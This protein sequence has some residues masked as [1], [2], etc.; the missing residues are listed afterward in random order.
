MPVRPGLGDILAGSDGGMLAAEKRGDERSTMTRSRFRTSV[1]LA[2]WLAASVFAPPLPAVELKPNTASAFDHYVSLTETQMEDDSRNGR[3]L[4]TDRLAAQRGDAIK[5]QLRRGETFVEPLRTLDDGHS[6]GVPHGLI[7]DWI[8]MAYIPGATLEET[9]SVLSDYDHHSEIYKPAVRDSKL[10]ERDG[11][12][13]KTYMRL[14]S[15]SIVT[16]VLDA[17]FTVDF[18]QLSSTRAETKSHST[19]IAEVEDAGEKDEHELPVGQDHGYVWRLN[20]YWRI[21]QADGGV[22]IQVESVALSR[23]VPW[24]F[25]WFVNPLVNNISRSYMSNTLI[26]TRR[27]VVDHNRA[28]RSANPASLPR[29][30]ATSSVVAPGHA[31]VGEPHDRP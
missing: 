4:F 22:Y 28:S 31:S 8:G 20:S 21:D 6:I 23:S 9:L 14:Y 15:K 30:S 29:S 17:N 1:V 10:L 24:I 7:H 27:A 26:A 2:A 19:K 18:R 11:T 12:T 16:V 13:R 5:A 25:A 3:F